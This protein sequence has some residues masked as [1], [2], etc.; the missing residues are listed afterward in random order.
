MPEPSVLV[1]DDS[2]DTCRMLAKLINKLG[3]PA[4]CIT[5]GEAALKWMTDH[6]PMLVILDMMMPG[7]DGMAVLHA[8][9][10]NDQLKEVA[11]VMF[12]AI[13]DPAFREYAI[14]EGANDYWVKSAID[15]GKLPEYLKPY[16]EPDKLHG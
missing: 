6:K 1:V 16:L 2:E 15:F 14:G 7:M 11:V 9:R 4:Q 3:P 10:S 13:S 8:M 5:S 12:S